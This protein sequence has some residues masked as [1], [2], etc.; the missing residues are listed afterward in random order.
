MLRI[1]LTL[2]IALALTTAAPSR[3]SDDVKITASSAQAGHAP[4]DAFDHDDT[5]SW[6]AAETLAAD[7]PSDWWEIDF[8]SNP[9]TLGAIHMKSGLFKA[10]ILQGHKTREF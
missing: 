1:A 3:A 2:T 9:R 10:G 7:S 8:Q 4:E 6:C 5:T